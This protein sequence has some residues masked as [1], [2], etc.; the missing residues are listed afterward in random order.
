[1][2]RHFCDDSEIIL[3]Y[4]AGWLCCKFAS[5]SLGLSAILEGKGEGGSEM[6]VVFL[7]AEDPSPVCYKLVHRPW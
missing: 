7:L 5:F 2:I 4:F 6:E 1:M 3:Q